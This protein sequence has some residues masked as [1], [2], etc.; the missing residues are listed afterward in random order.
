MWWRNC[1]MKIVCAFVIIVVLVREARG[2]RP[3]GAVGG[4]WRSS[5]W[6]VPLRCGLTPLDAPCGRHTSSCRS[7]CRRALLLQPV[8]SS[9]AAEVSY[10]PSSAARAGEFVEGQGVISD[11]WSD[12]VSAASK[13]K[14]PDRST[15]LRLCGP[16]CTARGAL[17]CL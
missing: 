11:P 3:G 16:G 9:A 1:K 13:L 14:N 17:Y 5:V 6:G 8:P 12:R 2:G 10:S 15:A 4:A 7:S